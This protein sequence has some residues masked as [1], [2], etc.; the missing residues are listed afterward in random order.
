MTGTP[1]TIY[2]KD[3]IDINFDNINGNNF[4]QFKILYDSY[5]TVV[6]HT[7]EK[8]YN[9]LLNTLL[10]SLNNNTSGLIDVGFYFNELFIE[11]FFMDGVLIDNLTKKNFKYIYYINNKN[12]NNNE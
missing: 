1:W 12:I 10:I 11:N 6:Y 9:D 7:G 5:F 2:N 8:I 4:K 3:L